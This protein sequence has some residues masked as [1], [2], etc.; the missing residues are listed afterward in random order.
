VSHCVFREREPKAFLTLLKEEDEPGIFV[1]V[2]GV[3]PRETIENAGVVY[4]SI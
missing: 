1:D 3:L 2:K 4:W